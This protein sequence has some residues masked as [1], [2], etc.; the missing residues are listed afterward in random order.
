MKEKNYIVK[1]RPFWLRLVLYTL[2][3]IFL[4]LGISLTTKIN[5][6]VSPIVSIAY[7]I[8]EIFKLKFSGVVFGLYGTFIIIQVVIHVLGKNMKRIMIDLGQMIVNL[9]F[10]GILEF[11]GSGLMLIANSNYGFIFSNNFSRGIVLIISIVLTG[12][13]AAMCLSMRLIPN[14]G[15]WDCSDNF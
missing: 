2:G 7:A 5:L 14:P 12:V 8:S 15:E 11:M 3:M 9:A 6:G 4:A 13:G 10:S 1:K